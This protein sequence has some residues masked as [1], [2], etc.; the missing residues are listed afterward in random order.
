MSEIFADQLTAV[1]NVYLL[2]S[3]SSRRSWPGLRSSSSRERCKRL[4]D[5]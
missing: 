5:R 3:R 4:S 2:S 1:A